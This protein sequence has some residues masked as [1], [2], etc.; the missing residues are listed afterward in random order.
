M[1]Q[2]ARR[3]TTPVCI[4]A[5]VWLFSTHAADAAEL[6]VKLTKP[7]PTHDDLAYGPHERNDMDVWLAESDTPTPV[8]IAVHGGGFYTGLKNVNNILLHECLDAGISVAAVGYRY[9]TDDIAPAPLHDIARAVQFVRAHADEWNLDATR[10]AA[11]G[12]S[13]GGAGA[14]WLALHDDL[15]D[16]DSDDPVARQSTRMVGAIA[17]NGQSTYD[18]RAIAKLFPEFDVAAHPA[19]P[20]LLGVEGHD[21]QN[22]TPAQYAVY[23]DCSA[24][25]HASADDPPVLLTFDRPMDIEI[26]TKSIGIHH[27]RFGT[28]L[29][30][31]LDPLGIPCTLIA[32]TPLP[33]GAASD[34]KRDIYNTPIPIAFLKQC[35]GMAD[36]ATPGDP[37]P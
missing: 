16:P 27:P 32:P 19:V 33:D 23:E 26:T 24:A 31:K 4:L 25:P 22:L 18:P 13:A 1:I 30:D 37:S 21:L 8:L 6:T 14:L 35:F 10:F 28:H 5:L 12:G 9:S 34:T 29:K 11:V 15:A 3:M 20:R 7:T 36:P 17:I 2:R